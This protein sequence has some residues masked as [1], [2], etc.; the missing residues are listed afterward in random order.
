[1]PFAQV[2]P[3]EVFDTQRTSD[4]PDLFDKLSNDTTNKP[5]DRQNKVDDTLDIPTSGNYAIYRCGKGR[6]SKTAALQR[7]LPIIYEILQAASSDSSNGIQSPYGFKA[8]FKTDDAKHRVRTVFETIMRGDDVYPE[9]EKAKPT[10]VC[11]APDDNTFGH[12]YEP[13]CIRNGEPAKQITGT[14]FV[15]L[16]PDFWSY[17]RTPNTRTCPRVANNAIVPSSMALVST[18]TSIHLH[19]LVH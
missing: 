1:M 13:Y 9:G 2:L 16:C 7:T 17:P 11:L 14:Q 12:L 6:R 10:I 19:E 15:F 5:A 18:R 8:L 4:R 3:A